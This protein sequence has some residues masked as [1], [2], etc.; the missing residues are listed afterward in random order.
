[1]IKDSNL[2]ENFYIFYT[3]R[4][5]KF[6]GNQSRGRFGSGRNWGNKLGFA[7]QSSVL[8]PVWQN[9]VEVGRGTAKV[10]SRSLF[11][12]QDYGGLVKRLRR[13]GFIPEARVRFPYPSLVCALLFDRLLQQFYFWK[14]Q[15][16]NLTHYQKSSLNHKARWYLYQNG[17]RYVIMV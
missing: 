12:F 16:V 1:M 11:S 14:Y 6:T 8:S 15:T 4:S 10:V 5:V 17:A 13:W 7:T 2:V 9:I 3:E